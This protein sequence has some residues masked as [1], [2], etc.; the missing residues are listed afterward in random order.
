MAIGPH[1]QAL[2]D[3]VRPGDRAN[4]N[5]G[6]EAWNRGS[7]ALADVASNIDRICAR[8]STSEASTG[9][10]AFSGQTASAA[11]TAFQQSATAMRERAEELIEARDA[12]TV[13]RVALR[14]A[15]R[16]SHRMGSGKDPGQ[17]PRPTTSN[18][19]Q[20]EIDEHKAWKKRDNAAKAD[21]ERRENDS[22][23]ALADLRAAYVRASA[24]MKKIHGQ[25]DVPPPGRPPGGN[26]DDGNGG[27]PPGGQTPVRPPHVQDPD[28]TDDTR[29][30]VQVIPPPTQVD[31]PVTT[32]DPPP[33][34]DPDPT[35]NGGDDE[36]AQQH[37]TR[38]EPP[39]STDVRPP[40][41]GGTSAPVGGGVGS[42]AA[43]AGLGSVGVAAGGLAAGI[44]GRPGGLPLSSVGAGSASGA[45]GALGGTS[46]A[47]GSSVLGRGG[48]GGVAG[49]ASTRGGAK[50]AAGGRG[51]ARA[52]AGASG[53]R[54]G[55]G[56]RGAGAVGAGGRRGGRDDDQRGADRDLFD[57]GQ[58]W[59]DDEEQGPGVLD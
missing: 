50:G 25:P 3:A 43:G 30:P 36:G 10:P 58:D 19:T 5:A 6:E 23:E 32:E 48:A 22:R 52:A 55:R 37:T 31:P 38:P 14:E 11:L 56:G 57:D 33:G 4:V 27:R 41:P 59:L 7:R 1:Q 53:S 45:R 16:E 26:D 24:A 42:V 15:T 13:A 34:G 12:L 54:G 21:Y 39:P 49:Q 20:A 8:L 47:G 2:A 46:R 35:D 18:P 40:G 28:P 29:P 51:G 17:E 44:G 9:Q